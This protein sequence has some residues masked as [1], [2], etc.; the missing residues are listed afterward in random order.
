M[1]SAEFQLTVEVDAA[2]D[3][4]VALL[5][6]LDQL[7]VLHP[8]IESIRELPPTSERPDARRY[9]VVDRLTLGWLRL[10]TVY[11]A[12]LRVLSE[13]RVEGRAWQRPG[14]ELHASYEVSDSE[15][16]TRVEERT[17]LRAPRLLLPIVRPQ[18]EAAHRR[19]LR[20]LGAHFEAETGG[21]GAS[22]H[23]AR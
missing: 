17:T 3:A 1:A 9:R 7:H 2:P 8:L 10:R 13:T 11:I 22:A 6:D 19:M 23:P 5:A 20:N 16:G 4:V 21:A 14:V 15:K 12:E 18:A